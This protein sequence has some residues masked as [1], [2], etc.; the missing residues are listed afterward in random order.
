MDGVFDI[1]TRHGSLGE[2]D[3]AT[4]KMRF[5]LASQVHDDF[6]EIFQIRLSRKRVIQVGWHD[7][8]QEI[9][10]VCDFLARQ[11]AAPRSQYD[12]LR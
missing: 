12:L 8:Q 2:I 9:E 10:V 4:W 3:G 1:V 5:R 11:F 6:D 7:T